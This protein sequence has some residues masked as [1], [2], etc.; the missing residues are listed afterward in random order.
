MNLA[1]Q[2]LDTARSV[3]MEHKKTCK[4]GCGHFILHRTATLSAMCLQ[5]TQLYKALLKCEDSII[6]IEQA[7]KNAKE[8]KAI[9]R[10]HRKQV[11]S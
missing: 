10:E 9:R 5:G 2:A 3:F 7:K 11:F 6:K 8:A 1:E 4:A